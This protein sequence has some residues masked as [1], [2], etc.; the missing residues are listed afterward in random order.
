MLPVI[1]IGAVAIQTRGLVLLLAFWLSMTLVERLARQEGLDEDP[2]WNG[3]ITGV[4]AGLIGAR[5]AYAAQ[6]S[7]L[8]LAEPLALFSLSFQSMAWGAGALVGALA[9]WFVLRRSGMPLWRVADLLAPALALFWALAAFSAFLSGDAYGRPAAGPWAISLW[10]AARHPVQL[11]EVAAGLAV[12]ALLLYLRRRTPYPGWLARVGI[13]ALAL[14]RL[15]VEG[16]RGD[17]EVIGDG[18]RL[19]QIAALAV[20][21][22]AL[23]SLRP[24]PK[25]ERA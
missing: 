4:V 10:D 22:V 15:F 3:A 12:M 25:V 19:A 13:L 5:L 23:W 14:T 2:L 20:A 21:L 18:I 7:D 11:Y 9:A 24:A 17:P 8:F 16:F 6:F 1:Q